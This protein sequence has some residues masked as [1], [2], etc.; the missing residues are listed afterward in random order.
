MSDK[1]KGFLSLMA[2]TSKMP[3]AIIPLCLSWRSRPAK[4]AGSVPGCTKR[5]CFVRHGQGDHNASIK[6]WQLCDPP[7]NAKGEG[8]VK[9]LATELKPQ[10]KQF[11]LIVVSPLTRAMQTAT[12]GFDG[13]KCPWAVQPLL[14]ERM[15]APC[16]SGRTKCELLRDFPKIQVQ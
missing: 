3:S 2:V 10:L 15:G 7:L 11:D 1:M 6:G 8:Q 16:D 4:K 12:G 14:R 5:V 9:Q 13:V